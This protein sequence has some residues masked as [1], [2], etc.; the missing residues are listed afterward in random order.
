MKILHYSEI[1]GIPEFLDSG[2]KSWTLDSECWT[3]D[4]ALWTL[5]SGRWNLEAGLWTLDSGPWTLSFTVV[6]QN[7]NS[8]SDFA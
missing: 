7:Q 1:F 4:A 8:V 6:E 2:R 5:E 3:L